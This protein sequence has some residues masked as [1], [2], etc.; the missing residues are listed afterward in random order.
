MYDLPPRLP[1]ETLTI[2]EQTAELEEVILDAFQWHLEEGGSLF[3]EDVQLEYPELLQTSELLAFLLRKDEL[4]DGAVRAAY[5]GTC[6]ALFLGMQ[7]MP[8]YMGMNADD[9]FVGSSTEEVYDKVI[10]DTQQYLAQSQAVDRL[11][12]HFMPELDPTGKY[13]FVVETAVAL[14]CIFM[15]KYLEKQKLDQAF[16]D[17]MADW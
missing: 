2:A 4:D 12:A 11:T 1:E 9:Y 6:F 3:D 17:I 15:D 10:E 7:L 14:T 5:A 16:N 8:N 13:A